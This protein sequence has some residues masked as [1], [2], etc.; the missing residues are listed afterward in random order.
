M[1]W[2]YNSVSVGFWMAT[3]TLALQDLA[4]YG[5][6]SHRLVLSAMVAQLFNALDILL[7]TLSITPNPPFPAVLQASAR[8]SALWTI[9]QVGEQHRA[10]APLI[11]AWSI[12]DMLRFATHLVR[13][14]A[15]LRY[16][17]F[18]LLYPIGFG[19]EMA[20]LWTLWRTKHSPL[21][22]LLLIIWPLGFIALFH[23]MLGQRRK[24]FAKLHSH[25]DHRGHH[26]KS[27]LKQN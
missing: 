14:L 23:Y 10:V 15:V 17:V 18:L 12:G 11:M 5:R 9:R 27:A 4:K 20:L 21:A 13:R 16:S 25:H 19:C 6:A 22:L 2:L 7:A 24:F 1:L 26:H 3:L 8:L